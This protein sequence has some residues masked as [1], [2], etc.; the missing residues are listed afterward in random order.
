MANKKNKEDGLME[1]KDKRRWINISF[2]SKWFNG[3][4][5]LLIFLLSNV[6]PY[7]F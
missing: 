6:T 3:E 4:L 7:F 1:S 2:K 5:R